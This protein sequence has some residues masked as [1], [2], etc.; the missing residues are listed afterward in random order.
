[1]EHRQWQK[2]SFEKIRRCNI[3]DNK[4]IITVNACVGSGKTNVAAFALGNFIKMNKDRRTIQMFVCPRIR[5]CAQQAEEIAE[6]I[7]SEFGL[8]RNVDFDMIRKDCTQKELNLYSET[9]RS[10][11]SIFV[12][13]DESL[14]GIDKS[15]TDPEKRW[16]AWI[17]FLNRRIS[18]GYVLGNCIFD[19]AHNYKNNHVKIFGEDNS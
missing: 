3:S 1:M 19:E 5:L 18:E 13:C 7:E 4:E 15:A 12:V 2:E 9:F 11:N 8:R 14:W 6:F 16:H 10:R 17:S